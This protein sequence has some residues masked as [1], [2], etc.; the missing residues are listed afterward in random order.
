MSRK[1][2]RREFVCLSAATV[3]T[4][5]PAWQ[6]LSFAIGQAPPIRVRKPATQAENEVLLLEKAL[7][8]MKKLPVTDKRNWQNQAKIHL[9]SCA[10]KNWFFLPWHRAYLY[11]FEAICREITG[12][13]TFALPYW[14]WTTQRQLPPQFWKGELVSTRQANQNSKAIDEYVG[15]EIIEKIL[16]GD[17]ETFAGGK[18]KRT[19]EATGQGRLENAPHNYIHTFVG[20]HMRT[21]MSPL[22]PIFWLHHANVDRL[23]TEWAKKK[24]A[25]PKDKN[26]LSAKMTF[27]GPDGKPA[28]T[29]VEEVLGTHKLGYRYDTQSE[30]DSEPVL[31]EPEPETPD[32]LH[33]VAKIKRP[34]DPGQPVLFDFQPSDSL[35]ERLGFVASSP[36][37]VAGKSAVRLAVHVQPPADPTIVV[38][39]FLNCP[40][41]SI[42]TPYSNPHHIGSF[43][44]FE[45]QKSGDPHTRVAFRPTRVFLDMTSTLRALGQEKL[46][47]TD[48]PITVQMM[49]ARLDSD[50]GI[51]P[52][53]L[54]PSGRPRSVA[55]SAELSYV[56]REMD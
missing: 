45:H 26:W 56:Q 42:D 29:A 16:D 40:S 50:G 15:K 38:R 7:V 47:D 28:S 22:D 21:F 37:R 33:S 44:F 13:A 41:L 39:V 8:A 3:G 34:P 30:T 11:Y 18:A 20:G 36:S 17:F 14:D 53:V 24:K 5:L 4:C 27:C 43:A 32:K 19:D 35:R 55:S 10:H 9:D 48:G 12:D 49:V 25:M 6:G 23:W 2:T 1:L 54:P 51:S 46:Y 52:D 31:A